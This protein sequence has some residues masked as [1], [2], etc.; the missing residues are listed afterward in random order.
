MR[1][2]LYFTTWSTILGSN[3]GSDGSPVEGPNKALVCSCGG[4]L[5]WA[6]LL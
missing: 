6:L 5:R 4:S 1:F 3:A 2:V